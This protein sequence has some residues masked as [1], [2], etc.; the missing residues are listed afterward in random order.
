MPEDNVGTVRTTYDAFLRRDLE[1]FLS[2]HDAAVQFKSL[3]LEVEGVYHGLDGLRS[4]WE[5]VLDVFPDWTPQIED[6]RE[7]GERVLL[8]VRVEGE[9]TG[10]GIG[11]ERHAWNVVEVRDG[12]ITSSAF[13]RTEE[14]ALEAMRRESG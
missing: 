1:G 14:E 9:G 8:R 12:R 6:A 4:W 7:V 11:L 2:H 13:F 5:T 3:V 10:T